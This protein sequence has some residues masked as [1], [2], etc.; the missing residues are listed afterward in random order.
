MRLIYGKNFES[1][2][3]DKENYNLQIR[4]LYQNSEKEILMIL[5]IY[6]L[7]IYYYFYWQNNKLSILFKYKIF[8]LLF[9]KFRYIFYNGDTL[10][11]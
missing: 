1:D 10:C 6:R 4:L 9:K 3:K 2:S 7:K 11:Q 8:K 5:I